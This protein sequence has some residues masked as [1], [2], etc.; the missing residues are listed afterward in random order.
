M[1]GEDTIYTLAAQFAG[2][3]GETPDAGLTALC[4]A[5]QTMLRR[6]LRPGV[7]QEECGACFSC[8]AAMLAAADFST[9][10]GAAGSF[11]VGDVS[12]SADA[13]GAVALRTQAWALMRP[14]CRQALSCMGVLG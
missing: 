3:S 5:A 11:R 14:F 6:M 9:A 12:V 7:T 10:A 2:V 8:A 4:T 1:N 13:R